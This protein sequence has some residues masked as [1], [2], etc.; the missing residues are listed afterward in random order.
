MT[1]LK[2]LQLINLNVYSRGKQNKQN[3]QVMVAQV[4][5]LPIIT[6][7]IFLIYNTAFVLKHKMSLQ[8]TADAATYSTALVYAR[9]LNFIAYTNRAMAANE[10]GIASV[11]SLHTSTSMLINATSN[12]FTAY[13]Y[14]KWIEHVAEIVTA[15]ECNINVPCYERHIGRAAA[16][17]TATKR[18]ISRADNHDYAQFAN[19]AIYR[20]GQDSLRVLNYI[21]AA[22]QQATHLLSF[23]EMPVV[24]KDVIKRNDSDAAIDNASDASKLIFGLDVTNFI[25]Q[26]LIFTNSYWDSANLSSSQLGNLLDS[27][28]RPADLAATSDRHKEAMRFAHVAKGS[29]DLFTVQRQ[30]LP[31][32]LIKLAT[33]YLPSLAAA[34]LPYHWAGG[35]ELVSEDENGNPGKGRIRWQSADRLNIKPA[36]NVAL[37]DHFWR[38][39]LESNDNDVSRVAYNLDVANRTDAIF[40]VGIA[41]ASQGGPYVDESWKGEKLQ[42]SSAIPGERSYGGINAGN[43]TVLDAIKKASLEN[44]SLF[45]GPGNDA[46]LLEGLQTAVDAVDS[47]Y[48]E[49]KTKGFRNAAFYRSIHSLDSFGAESVDFLKHNNVHAYAIFTKGAVEEAN[50]SLTSKWRFGPHRSIGILTSGWPMPFFKDV[51]KHPQTV[52]YEYDSDLSDALTNFNYKDPLESINKIINLSDR[53]PSFAITLTKSGKLLNIRNYD[54]ELKDKPDVSTIN[55]WADIKTKFSYD[56]LEVLSSAGVY[57]RRPQDHWGRVVDDPQ[58][59]KGA[60]TVGFTGG[61]IEHKNLFS[62]YWHVRNQQPLLATRVA[63]LLPHLGPLGQ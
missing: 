50:D 14:T 30:I 4:A 62:P 58:K 41:T 22:S 21:I 55:K 11:A 13:A 53:G 8:N 29:L 24:A 60:F 26:C 34:A 20:V 35:T 16:A 56:N 63:R 52:A 49:D 45:P 2:I 54:S 44:T 9:T 33:Y 10:A 27:I 6:L 37:G 57:F 40:G 42:L 31:P 15:G 18:N 3:G 7:A 46:F 1:R 61:Y 19:D 47:N 59:D 38:N 25:G 5:A 17:W 36:M 28:G 43:G 48:T 32:A 23:V 39:Y 12:G 51:A